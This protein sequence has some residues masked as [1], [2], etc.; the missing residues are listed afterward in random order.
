MTHP[1]MMPDP[2]VLRTVMPNGY[3]Y[4]HVY[5]YTAAQMEA[6]AAAKV[7]EAQAWQPIETAPKDGTNIILADGKHATVGNWYHEEPY[8]HEYRDLGG[9][10]AGQDEGDGFNGWVDWSGGI[11]PT[12][13]MPLP[14]PPSD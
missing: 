6:Y 12:H 3:W 7:R 11:T 5:G 8:I 4:G 14:P 2:V 1:V 13:W 9:N 10:Y